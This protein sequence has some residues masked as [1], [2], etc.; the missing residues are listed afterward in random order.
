MNGAH[1]L[2]SGILFRVAVS[3]YERT[4]SASSEK[5]GGQNDALVSILFSAA[6][7]EAFVNELALMAKVDSVLCGYKPYQSIASIL[8]ETEDSHGSIR[9]KFLLSRVI[10]GGE[11]YDKGAQPY[12]DFDTLFSIRDAIVH[13]KPEKLNEDPKKILQ[14]LRAKGICMDDEPGVAQSWLAQITTRAVARWACN[15]VVDMVDSL[16]A[17]L[18]PEAQETLLF[19]AILSNRY[20]R[21]K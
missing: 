2:N 12:Q 17:C 5:A 4:E 13:L 10:L 8:N 14:R 6:T 16:K 18:P 20:D 15:I 21:V 11:T 7:L 19:R 9:L 3:A 1:F